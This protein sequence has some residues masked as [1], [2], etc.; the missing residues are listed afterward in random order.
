MLDIDQHFPNMTKE[1][2]NLFTQLCFFL[3]IYLFW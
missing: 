3:I 1:Q 2:V